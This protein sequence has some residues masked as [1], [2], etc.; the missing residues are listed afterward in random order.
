MRAN[1]SQ[2][3][4]R[5]VC[6]DPYLCKARA[7]HVCA[8]EHR[9]DASRSIYLVVVLLL[10][11]AANSSAKDSD[12]PAVSDSDSKVKAVESSPADR[13]DDPD[14]LDTEPGRTSGYVVVEFTI[15][16]DGNPSD[17]EVLDSN[18]KG[19]FDSSAI[20]SLQKWKFKPVGEVRRVTST[21]NFEY[22]KSDDEEERSD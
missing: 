5:D 11:I 6:H 12:Q 1:Q 18:P 16:L 17:F 20:E 3:Q 14:N 9:C 19:V 4:T 10:V 8:A 2:K 22:G 7:S 21:I 15:D 13:E